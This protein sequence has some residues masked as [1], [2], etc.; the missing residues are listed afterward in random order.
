MA[1]SSFNADLYGPDTYQFSVPN[2][3]SRLDHSFRDLSIFVCLKYQH[4]LGSAT[5]DR[6]SHK[7]KR[8]GKG[9]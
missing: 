7:A 9:R 5:G 8:D 3:D 6:S 1:S 4:Y 2:P